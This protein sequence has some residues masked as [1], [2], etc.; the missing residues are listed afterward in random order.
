MEKKHEIGYE[1]LP[2]IEH[3][4]IPEIGPEIGDAEQVQKAEEETSTHSE[5]LRDDDADIIYE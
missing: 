1:N 2:E 3:Q 4:E 5:Q